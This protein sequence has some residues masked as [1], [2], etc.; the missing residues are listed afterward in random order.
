MSAT[1][2]EAPAEPVPRAARR[3]GGPE[4]LVEYADEGPVLVRGTASSRL[5]T[6]SAAPPTRMWLRQTRRS[7]SAT[8]TSSESRPCTR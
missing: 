3:R 2:H 1:P 4:V 5:Y 6:F 7:S 8:R